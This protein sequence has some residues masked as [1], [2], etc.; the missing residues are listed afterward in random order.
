LVKPGACADGLDIAARVAVPFA[1]VGIAAMSDKKAADAAAAPKKGGKLKVIVLIVTIMIVECGL[2][3]WFFGT[4]APNTAESAESHGE[5]HEEEEEGHDDGEGV[6]ISLGDFDVTAFQPTSNTTLRVSFKLYGTVRPNDEA[7][8]TT[9]VDERKHRF[10]EQVLEIIR[11]SEMNDLTDPVL[12]LIK[13]KILEKTN[14]LLGKAM[15]KGVVFSDFSY[16][17]Q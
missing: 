6:E 1:S 12:G 3:Y 8:V 11:S 10:R 2:A 17:E 14:R 9:L 16:Y 5:E 15:I 7:T 13:R 4:A